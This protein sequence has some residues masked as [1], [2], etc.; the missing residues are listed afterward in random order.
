M[1]ISPQWN[2]P[3]QK[4]SGAG[5]VPV[6]PDNRSLCATAK[7]A[8]DDLSPASTLFASSTSARLASSACVVGRVETFAQDFSRVLGHV[9]ASPA[10][11]ARSVLPFNASYHDAWPS[12]YTAELADMVYRAHE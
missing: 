2:T 3:E 11:R 9:R 6:S 10:L 7:S 4:P 8:V 12:Y 1:R 5:F